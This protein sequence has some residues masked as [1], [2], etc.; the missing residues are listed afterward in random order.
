[1]II[2]WGMDLSSRTDAATKDY[3]IRSKIL[4]QKLDDE[5]EQVIVPT[6]TIAELLAPIP[7]ADHGKFIAELQKRFFCPPFDLR[8]AAI[9]AEL[10]QKHRK[11]PKNQQISERSTLKAD[12]Y[13][14]ATAKAAGASV[15]YS[16][17][18]NCRRLAQ[19]VMTARD[20]P[21]RHPNM[22]VDAEI[23]KGQK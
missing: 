3:I 1:M 4:L 20:L 14:I 5:R 16:H 22:F 21:T 17:D 12:I 15:F 7:P 9:A 19:E 23:R 18:A 11:F 8:G 10:W 6:I 13:I 2:I